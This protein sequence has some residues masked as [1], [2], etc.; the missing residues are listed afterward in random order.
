MLVCRQCAQ[1]P[2]SSTSEDGCSSGRMHYMKVRMPPLQPAMQQALLERLPA[3]LHVP[4]C[5][6]ARASSRARSASVTGS[7]AARSSSTCRCSMLCR[8][9][10]TCAPGHRR[11]TPAGLAPAAPRQHAPRAPRRQSSYGQ[12]A[13]TRARCYRTWQSGDANRVRYRGDRRLLGACWAPAGRLSSACRAPAGRL[14]GACWAPV[15][16]LSSAC[17]APAGRLMGA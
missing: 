16:R 11:V 14:L 3:T 12:D 10:M 5:M 1:G 13:P 2:T 4:R 17:W 9:S 7:L 15:E 6:G 8:C